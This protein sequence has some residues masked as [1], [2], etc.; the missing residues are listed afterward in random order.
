MGDG[1]S[2][3][4]RAAAVDSQQPNR[5]W[6]VLAA[7]LV[8]FVAMMEMSVVNV[9]LPVLQQELGSSPAASQ[10][11]VL[12][13]LLPIVT[14]VLPAG[15]WLDRVGKRPA[16]LLAVGGFLLASVGAGNAPGIGVLIAARV[17]Q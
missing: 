12:G 9:T 3:P 8:S 7:G 4:D 14:L 5:W 1:H 13:Y 11:I 16:M 6:L 15:R 10:W 17:V 2:S